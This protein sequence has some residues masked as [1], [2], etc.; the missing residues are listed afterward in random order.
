MKLR[1]SYRPEHQAAGRHRWVHFLLFAAAALLLIGGIY[2]L[3]LFF[4]D[5]NHDVDDHSWWYLVFAAIYLAIGSLLAYAGI[6]HVNANRHPGE[7]YVR[8]DDEKLSWHLTQ[9]GEAEEVA[10]ADIESVAEP[11]VRDLVI[12]TKG[13]SVKTLPIYLIT[14]PAKQRGLVA[15][16]DGL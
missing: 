12:T 4:T 5:W 11:N 7:R 15:I 8:V 13:G 10:L 9:T 16:L 1:Y 6:R 3:F 14:D 2:E